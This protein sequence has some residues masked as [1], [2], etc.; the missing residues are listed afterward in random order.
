MVIHG[1]IDGYSRLVLYLHCANNNLA[2]T[3]L[4]QFVAATESHFIPSRVRCDKGTE[5]IEVAKFMLLQ[6]GFDRGSVITG[7]SVHNQRIE[8]LWRDVFRAVT[9]QY[10]KL[11]YGMEAM[12][13][14]NPLDHVHLYA[15]H[16]TYIPR[17]NRSL[18]QF[19]NGWNSHGISH[20]KNMSPVQILL[21]GVAKMHSSQKIADDFNKTVSGHYGIDFAGPTSTVK[22]LVLLCLVLTL[23]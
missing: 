18:E 12:G 11:F 16:I 22:K 9:F 7:S 5:N 8:R 10:Y 4:Q 19:K 15:L 1:A 17:I 3:V 6:R 23:N 21:R 14:L 2:T 13:M 20:A